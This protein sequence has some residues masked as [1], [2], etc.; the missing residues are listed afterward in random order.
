MTTAGTANPGELTLQSCAAHARFMLGVGIPRD[1]VLDDYAKNFGARVGQD[2]LPTR[3]ELATEV[4]R[5]EAAAER[6]VFGDERLAMAS[7]LAF[8]TE[9]G[10]EGEGEEGED[11]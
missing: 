4:D 6:I 1:K 10:E 5:Q 8:L 7:V 2:G 3:E 9:L 11:A